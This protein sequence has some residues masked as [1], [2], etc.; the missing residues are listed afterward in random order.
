MWLAAF[1]DVGFISLDG[2]LQAAKRRIFRK[3]HCR[4]QTMAHEPRRL[5]ADAEHAMNL[6]PRNA[7]LRCRHQEQRRKPFRERDFAFLKNGFDRDGEL[8]TAGVALIHAWP[9][10]LAAQARDPVPIGAA[11]RTNRTIRPPVRFQPLAGLGFVRED[12]LSQVGIQRTSLPI[13]G[14]HAL[15]ITW[16]KERFYA[17]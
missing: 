16:S 15:H 4:A 8:L 13:P 5:V 1:A 7:L 11:V 10:R 2:F 6:M 9:M 17:L 12:R 14:S 3:I